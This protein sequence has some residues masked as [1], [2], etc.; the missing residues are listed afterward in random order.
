[1]DRP[2]RI[3]RR[4][5]RRTGPIRNAGGAWR[6]GEPWRD[7]AWPGDDAASRGVRE[8]YRV[9]EEQI[10]RGRRMAQEIGE[11]AWDEGPY[12][13]RRRRRPGFGGEEGG[14]HG[15]G[16]FR[17][18]EAQMRRTE[19]LVQEIL[20]QISSARPNPWRLAELVFRL[21]VESVSDLA[22]LG[23]DALAPRREDC[24]DEETEWFDSDEGCFDEFEDGEDDEDGEDL[25]GEPWDWPTS[26]APT[27]VRSTVPIP[28]HVSSHEQ[29]EVDLD[30]PTGSQV[31]T[32]EVER[33]LTS[34]IAHPLRPAFDAELVALA[35]GLSILRIAVPHDLPAG[36]YQRRILSRATG[37]P[38]GT[39]T[40]QVGTVPAVEQP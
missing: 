30:L 29:T 37:E 13:R 2:R 35:G 17:F 6:E 14:R 36:R 33:P 32:F 31:R 20:R 1:M 39:L 23:F 11:E 12:D 25:D 5:P 9:I 7:S 21:Y 16:G 28:V 8:G 18:L 27:V 19:R 40:I 24:F 10:R 15:R 22:F 34:G 38:V 4:D 3:K 26:G